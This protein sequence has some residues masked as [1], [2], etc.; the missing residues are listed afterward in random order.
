MNRADDVAA[1]FSRPTARCCELLWADVRR[2]GRLLAA[3][4]VLMVAAG[5]APQ[6]QGGRSAA[7]PLNPPWPRL[8]VDVRGATSTIPDEAAFY[9]PLPPDALVPARGF[10]FDAGAHAYAG[11]LGPARLGF[12]ASVLAVRA[13]QGEQMTVNARVFS[14]QV[15]FNFGGAQG[16]SYISGGPGVAQVRGRLIDP[17]GGEA[18]SRSSGSLL[19]LHV[20]GGARWFVTP[21][22]AVTFD[23]RF[24]R[25]GSGTGDD[26]ITTGT[27]TLIAASVG[28]SLK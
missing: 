3:V 10:G 21:H 11:H 4:A 28:V 17:N 26:G 13:T 27:A 14:P 6:A 23:V 25:L 18:A 24:H 8:V 20:G 19:A 12:G 22:M 2:A 15:S 9:P 5:A 7:P 1:G 16:W